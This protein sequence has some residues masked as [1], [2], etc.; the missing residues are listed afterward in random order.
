MIL[1][2]ICKDLIAP[3]QKLLTYLYLDRLKQVLVQYQGKEEG[4]F[5]KIVVNS[6]NFLRCCFGHFAGG[7]D[8]KFLTNPIIRLL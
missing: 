3:L 7:T 5:Y 1:T 4:T 2:A 8:L 6:V